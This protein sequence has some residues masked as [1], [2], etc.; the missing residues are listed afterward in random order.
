MTAKL[1]AFSFGAVACA[2]VL[3]GHPTTTRAQ[4][5]SCS[6][7]GSIT[8]PV[9][10]FSGG[11]AVPNCAFVTYDATDLFLG[12][13]YSSG[14]SPTLSGVQFDLA[15]S[16]TTP[17]YF[18]NAGSSFYGD[19]AQVLDSSFADV[20]NGPVDYFANGLEATIPL[21]DI[22]GDGALDFV[23][24]T[25]TELALDSDEF[26]GIEYELPDTGDGTSAPVE[27]TTSV[28]EPASFFLLASGLATLIS[29]RR[30]A[31][32]ARS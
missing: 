2:A 29:L 23:V 4:D 7:P 22:G 28:P 15:T 1:L 19:T 21:A 24:F 5:L 27:A 11:G 31:R 9:G 18:V 26:T 3:I 17:D 8:G 14:F 10:G 13:T 20:G 32:K 25:D 30:R 6:G 12:V 16:G